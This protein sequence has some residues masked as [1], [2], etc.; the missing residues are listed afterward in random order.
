MAS[1][2]VAIEGAAWQAQGAAGGG[3]ADLFNEAL[4]GA[5]H[6]GSL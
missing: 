1:G 3:H 2:S 6:F 5:D 4:G